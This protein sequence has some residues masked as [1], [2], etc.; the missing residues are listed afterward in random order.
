MKYIREGRFGKPKQYKTGAIV[1]TYPKPMLVAEL[2]IGGLEIYDK[3]KEIQW[4]KVEE[5]KA[6]EPKAVVSAIDLS[7][8]ITKEL[9]ESYGPVPDDM[10]FSETVRLI[11]TLRERSASFP[12]KTF[13]IDTATGL[14]DCIYSHLAK[15]NAAALADPR[16]WASAVGAKVGQVIRYALSLPCHV[17]VIMHSE[18]NKDELTGSTDEQPMIYSKLRE[19][20][21]ALFSQ[22]LYAIIE[23]GKP[24]VHTQPFGL[25]KGVGC[26]WPKGLPAVCGA[27]FTSIYGKEDFS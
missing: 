17:V 20:I 22:F 25:V 6:I 13:V 9:N 26:R 21:G 27:D 18:T 3:P 2:E 4:L 15:R 16:K 7:L 24:V 10:A 19:S 23:N 8:C 14:S 12:W 5:V 1:N 11:N